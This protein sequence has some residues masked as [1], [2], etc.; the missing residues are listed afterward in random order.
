M[1]YML[2]LAQIVVTV[3]LWYNVVDT[4]NIIFQYIEALSKQAI[5]DSNQLTPLI[6]QQ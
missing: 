4:V 3:W 5:T 1:G 6:I 2:K